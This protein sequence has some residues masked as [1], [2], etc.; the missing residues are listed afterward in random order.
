MMVANPRFTLAKVLLN[1]AE[2]HEAAPLL[3]YYL[4]YAW[5]MGDRWSLTP[6][7]EASGIALRFAG[8]GER[9][10]YLMGAADALRTALPFPLSVAEREPI[11]QHVVSL[12]SALGP[13]AYRVAWVAGHDEPLERVVRSAMDCLAAV[14]QEATA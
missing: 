9:A 11:Q 4:A 8:Q 14:G 2:L 6:A 7:L 10:A 1:Q 12:Q 3:I 13:S 5:E